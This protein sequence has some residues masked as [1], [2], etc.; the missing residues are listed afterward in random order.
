MKRIVLIS[1]FCNTEEKLQILKNKLIELKSMGIDSMILTQ[2]ELPFSVIELATY[3]F[4]TWDN[5]I[6]KWPEFAILDRKQI[7]ENGKSFFLVKGHLDYGFAHAAQ[8]KTLSKIALSY[9]YEVFYFMNYDLLIDEKVV[10]ALRSSAISCNLWPGQRGNFWARVTLN[11]MAFDRENLIKLIESISREQYLS[12]RIANPADP[13]E[14]WIDQLCTEILSPVFEEFPVTD[15]VNHYDGINDHHNYSKIESAKI[16]IQKCNLERFSVDLIVY[17]YAGEK[18]IRVK[19]NL[20]EE[21]YTG[22]SPAIFTLAK[23]TDEF[24][25]TVMID[26]DGESQELIDDIRG[27]DINQI[28]LY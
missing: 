18:T 22:L 27:I 4:I 26:I 14:Y 3:C 19:T 6:I 2:F 7:I 17:E 13:P 21:E 8:Y 11:F 9:D 25:T 28:V 5:P 1:T 20:G 16:F 10:T 23:D 15:L 24:L 12:N